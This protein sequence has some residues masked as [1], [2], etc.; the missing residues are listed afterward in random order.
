MRLP[1]PPRR[2]RRDGDPGR[3]SLRRP[4]WTLR[5]LLS[6]GLAAA[7]AATALHVLAPAAAP[8]VAAVVLA[9]DL[10]SGHVLAPG[11]LHVLELP[12]G[13][14]P[15]GALAAG[16]V[17]SGAAAGRA[18]AGPAG[19]GEVVTTARL[20]GP[21]LLTGQPAGRVAAPVRVADAEAAALAQVGGRVDVMVATD[22]AAEAQV[23]ATAATVLA[24]AGA[25]ADAGGLLGGGAARDAG[26]G[27][28]LVLAVTPGQAA[29]LAAA[30]GRGPL[31]ITLR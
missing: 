12:V 28:L 4:P 17:A 27:G 22:G 29:D 15:P 24:V 16:A 14:L 1:Q 5:R 8:T 23:V 9:R 7:A 13:S 21:G 10:P 20:V 26:A 31:A 6:A 11:D 3:V 2:G 18:L 30:A 25:G 19:A